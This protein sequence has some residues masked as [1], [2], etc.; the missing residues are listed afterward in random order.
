MQKFPGPYSQ[1]VSADDAEEII[2]QILNAHLAALPQTAVPRSRQ[3]YAVQECRKQLANNFHVNTRRLITL[4][5]L[6]CPGETHVKQEMM[7]TLIPPAEE[8]CL[9]N[10]SFWQYL[11]LGPSLKAGPQSWAFWH[12]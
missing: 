9:L 7:Q 11:I 12:G 8:V 3:S 10:C 4:A 5:L 2:W 6:L 1:P